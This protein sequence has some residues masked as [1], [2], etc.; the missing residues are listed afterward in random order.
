MPQILDGNAVRDQ[1]K[2]GLR[3]RIAALPR[4]PG[5]PVV[6]VG[7]NPASEIYVRNKIRA[8]ADLIRRSSDSARPSVVGPSSVISTW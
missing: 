4:R 8:C 1:I 7:S 5:L 2:S 3:P 6:L